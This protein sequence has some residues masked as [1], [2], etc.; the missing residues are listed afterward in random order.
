MQY[1]SFILPRLILS[2]MLP[3]DLVLTSFPILSDD[4]DDQLISATLLVHITFALIVSVWL[5]TF[6]VLLVSARNSLEFILKYFNALY[7]RHAEKPP[8]NPFFEKRNFFCHK[9]LIY[10]Y[11]YICPLPHLQTSPF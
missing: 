10:I 7:K 4:A 1:E 11:I 5:S 2:V 8:R 6:K 3:G 9:N